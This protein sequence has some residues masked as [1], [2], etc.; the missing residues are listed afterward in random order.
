MSSSEPFPLSVGVEPSAPDRPS[1]ARIVVRDAHGD[2]CAD[3][4]GT[5]HTTLP[6]GIYRVRVEFAG[7]L[8]EEIRLH[9]VPGQ[10][11][12][13]EPP[14]Y[15]AVPTID[16]AN[17]REDHQVAAM[18]WSVEATTLVPRLPRAGGPSGSLFIFLRKPV[19]GGGPPVN[20]EPGLRVLTYE[21][22]QLVSLDGETTQRD[23][24]GGWI[25]F[26]AS[27]P[28]GRYVLR[29][30]GVDGDP[31]PPREMALEIFSGWQ[32]QLF[33]LYTEGPL[34]GSASIL[35]GYD[36]GF[37]PMT[38]SAAR[39]MWRSWGTENGENLLPASE[40][41]MLLDGKFANPILGLVG[42][43]A[44]LRSE[45]LDRKRMERVI[46]PPPTSASCSATLPMSKPSS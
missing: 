21:N 1:D 38:G 42:A 6:Q 40:M 19:N 41:Q 7:A 44:L 20:A 31:S 39:S 32:T 2:V 23:E 46:L 3:G 27:L 45:T 24:S 15:S 34:F 26:H 9:A 22:D 33:M 5:L 37:V 28:S 10:I 12:I 13:R 35:M 14:R 25:A 30:D 29:Y 4:H 18:R 17:G 11:T 43:H 16:V 8:D 36:V